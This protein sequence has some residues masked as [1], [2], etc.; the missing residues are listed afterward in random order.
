MPYA[1]SQRAT[2]STTQDTMPITMSL[3]AGNK[4]V[5]IDLEQ[6]EHPAKHEGHSLGPLLHKDSGA[7]TCD[8]PEGELVVADARPGRRRC[9]G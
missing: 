5:G 1:A 4:H 6:D 3:E 7:Y 9:L 8:R 2:S